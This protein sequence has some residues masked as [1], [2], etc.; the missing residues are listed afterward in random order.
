VLLVES[1]AQLSQ[2]TI[3]DVQKSRVVVASW[4]VFA[5]QD[6][7]TSL[8]QFTAMPE[9]TITGRRAFETWLRRASEEI[10]G[11]VA[12]LQSDTYEGFKLATDHK[13]QLRLQQ[14]EFKH[15]LPISIQ[16]G[17][18]YQSYKTMQKGSGSAKK[19]A[20]SKSQTSHKASDAK[21]GNHQTPLLHMFRFNRVLIDEYHYLNIGK[22]LE[23]VVASV[24][25]KE[26]SAHKRWV[27]SGTPALQ[28]FSDVDDLASYLG[29]RLGRRCVD[30]G[31]PHA[32]ETTSVEEFLSQIE[33]MSRQWHIARHERAQE[34]LDAF[35]RQNEPSLDHIP[36][37]ER[38]MP[39]EMDIGHHAVYLEL[40]QHLIS[41][42]THIKKLNSKKISDRAE[43]LN[44]SLSNSASAEDALLRSA[45]LFETSSGVSGLDLLSERR[46]KQRRSTEE[47]LRT[48]MA[49]LEG[50]KKAGEIAQ[51]YCQ[52]KDDITQYNWLGDEDASDQARKLP[53]QLRGNQF[54]RPS[55]N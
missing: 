55:R 50:V 3:E 45:L 16:H 44:S 54:A 14:P 2:L 4:S 29:V 10:P 17:Q 6:H 37:A 48:L 5:E 38:I 23:N 31:S 7:I 47:E 22:T 9:P 35:V 26:I 15:V 27:L 40:S 36:C 39:I 19:M 28:N 53:M 52:F 13:L 34:F 11:Q 18:A 42:K 41:Q 12:A 46:S 1:F 33:P 32:A 8:A 43:R 24:S 51:W 20:N 49:G 21:R 25:V 30:F